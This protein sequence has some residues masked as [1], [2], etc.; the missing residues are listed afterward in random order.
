MILQAL[1]LTLAA[2]EADHLLGNDIEFPPLAQEIASPEFSNYTDLMD[3]CVWQQPAAYAS[4]S[5]V[6][7]FTYKMNKNATGSAVLSAMPMALFIPTAGMYTACE[8]MGGSFCYGVT[9][10]TV[11]GTT[12]VLPSCTEEDLDILLNKVLRPLV[13][14]KVLPDPA[15][16]AASLVGF[17]CH[18]EDPRFSDDNAAVGVVAFLSILGFVSLLCSFVCRLYESKDSIYALLEGK[19]TIDDS[20]SDHE[21]EKTG[22]VRPL[23]RQSGVDPVD[24]SY[25]MKLCYCWDL[26]A[27]FSELMTT[28]SR[29]TNFL[30]MMRVVSSVWIV[31]LHTAILPEENAVENGQDL[32]EYFKSFRAYFNVPGLYAVDTFFFLSAFLVAL[33]G[34]R[35]WPREADA[36]VQ[37]KRVGMSYVDRY[38]RI[39]PAYGVVILATYNLFMY[40]S[41]GPFIRLG[42]NGGTMARDCGADWWRNLLFI[43][44]FDDFSTGSCL[45]HC[46]Y[47]ACDFQLMML[48]V[49]IVLG[50]VHRSRHTA[51]FTSFLV[52]ASLIACYFIT[53]VSDDQLTGGFNKAYVKPWVRAPPY[54]YGLLAAFAYTSKDVNDRIKAVVA[55]TVVRYCGYFASA[56]ILL[57]CCFIPWAAMKDNIEGEKW[58]KD[59]IAWSQV[60]YHMLW[61]I[62]LSILTLIFVNGHGGWVRKMMAHS[63]WEPLSKLTFTVYLVHPFIL[64]L[65]KISYGPNL[66]HFSS[67]WLTLASG[68]VTVASY[69][70]AALLFVFIE[71]PVASTWSLVSGRSQRRAA[72]RK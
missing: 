14:Q 51:I 18:N 29:P 24:R 68:N 35:S 37:A 30:N 45:G 26:S 8:V 53:R 28:S 38:I 54:L 33:V 43:N 23:N 72:V 58:S 59:Q 34:V 65:L 60:A 2:P 64:G 20:D 49:L 52:F 19:K 41:S 46:W 31:Y 21:D 36:P 70:T 40:V 25:I 10:I 57:G 44:N 5:T 13:E 62:G 55:N 11:G 56:A 48:G 32:F 15:G 9:G 1:L 39:V 12:C 7:W 4:V 17:N 69:V 3:R 67:W 50:Y 63:V 6:N 16:I 71:R 61:G 47:L 22:F 66:V 42:K 27:A